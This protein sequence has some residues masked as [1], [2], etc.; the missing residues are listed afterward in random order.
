GRR[1][2]PALRRRPL[3]SR[4]VRRAHRE[5]RHPRPDQQLSAA[6]Q[7]V[8]R[9]EPHPR[10]TRRRLVMTAGF[11][12]VHA[13]MQTTVQDTR[14]RQGLWDVGVPP[15]G[16]YDDLT[17]ERLNRM[18]GNPDTAA[19]LECVMVGPTLVVDAD[20]IV[21]IGGAECSPTVDGRAIRCGEPVRVRAGSILEVGPLDG[22]GMRAYLA[23]QGGLDTPRV[24]GS[25]ATFLLGGFGGHEGRSLI[26]GDALPIRPATNLIEPTTRELPTMAD[27]WELR[28]IPGPHGAPDYLTDDGV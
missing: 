9:V 17:L 11:R 26:A 28:V 23:V 24:L 4:E 10:P 8:Q 7:P 27:Q 21:A 18:L 1:G 16:A 2:E 15:S 22:L 12:V 3:G 6:Q 5:P 20:V 25:R 19:G 13:G 14:G